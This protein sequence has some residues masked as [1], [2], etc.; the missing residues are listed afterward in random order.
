MAQFE[1]NDRWGKAFEGIITKITNE[2][3]SLITANE[4]YHQD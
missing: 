4:I 2:D 3:G 1:V